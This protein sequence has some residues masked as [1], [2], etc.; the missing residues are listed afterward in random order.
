MKGVGLLVGSCI[1]RTSRRLGRLSGAVVGAL[2]AGAQPGLALVINVT[3]PNPANVPA[4]AQTEVNDVVALLQS[5]FINNA[6]ISITVDFT[7]TCGLGCNSTSL[8]G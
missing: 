5:S 4:A 7:S 6:T 2:F 3:Y 1:W 8:V